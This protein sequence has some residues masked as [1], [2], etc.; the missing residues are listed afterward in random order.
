MRAI[1]MSEYGAPEVLR[2]VEAPT[3]EPGPGQVRVRT[4][5]VGV[6]PAD[7]K[8]RAGWF[9]ERLPLTFPHIP[10]YDGAGVVDALGAGAQDL[11]VGDRV[12]FMMPPV[13]QG[14]YAEYVVMPTA[15]AAPIPS[16][17]D[18]AT[19][20]ALPTPG[21]TGVQLIED[22]IAPAPRDIVLITGAVGGVGRFSVRAAKLLGAR[23]VAAVRARQV[24]EARALGADE[25]IVLGEEDWS[26]PLFDHVADTVGGPEVAKLCLRMKPG[27]RLCTVSTTPIDPAG[28]PAEP[29]FIAVRQDRAKLSQLAQW[30]ASG[31]LP[32]PVARRMPLAQAPEAQRLME[33]GGQ[34]G[35]I[36]LEL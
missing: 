17:L 27:G 15:T 33:A 34:N 12:V 23:V 8:W 5:A 35:K 14:A 20:A 11:A 24:E 4:A 31:E 32:V 18:F 7:F 22:H 10:G 26:G 28:L 13:A 36:V 30:A 2:L 9:K 21:L 25:V 29:L 3:P 19:A 16:N 6:N 1:Q